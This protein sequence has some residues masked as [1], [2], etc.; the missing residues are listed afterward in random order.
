MIRGKKRIAILGS[1]LSGLVAAYELQKAIEAESLPFEFILIEKKE[2]IGGLIKTVQTED[3]PID[4]GAASFDVR[5]D[6]VRPFLTELGLADKIQYSIGGKL[7]RFTAN[8]FLNST[9]P[10]YH[11]IPVRFTDILH[12]KDLSLSD[13]MSV[14]INHSF[15]NM[16]R[17]LD[18]CT[19]TAEF[20]EY[21]FCKRVSTMIAY[22]N[23][24]ENVFGSME[25]CPPAFFDKNLVRLF[26]HTDSGY[27]LTDAELADLVDGDG[28][29]YTLQGGM[30]TLVEALKANIPDV[31]LTEKEITNL[32]YMEEDLFLMTLNQRESLRAKAIISTLSIAASA[33]LLNNCEAFDF[34]ISK[35]HSSSMATVLYRFKKGVLRR[36][37]EGFGFVV[38]KRS[39]FHI[40][41]AILLN[42]KWPS[43]SNSECDLLLVDI[44][45]NQ[46]DTLIQLPD[47]AFLNILTEE[48]REIFQME[49]MYESVKVHRWMHSV[50]HL[51][52]EMRKVLDKPDNRMKE[53]A[54]EKGFF[55]GGNGLNGYGLPNAIKEGKRLAQEA[56][57]YMKTLEEL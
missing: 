36:Y 53:Q 39:S 49:G 19:T 34:K 22:P 57:A 1:G 9:K 20:L 24:P 50:P 25:L 31:I 14:M 51:E 26:V 11:G 35:S 33:P 56:I 47:E 12:E 10:S 7:D 21:R 13:K 45:R 43:L 40:T 3:G 52:P 28:S 27:T 42:R 15:N 17:G 8:E 2:R 55:L 4:V 6:D 18:P 48:I 5:R 16:Q 46:E 29:E 32:S 38:P 41:K 37:P 23:Y 54:N 44:G 30:V